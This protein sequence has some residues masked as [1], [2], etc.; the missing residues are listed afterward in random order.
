MLSIKISPLSGFIMPDIILSKVVFP[1]PLGP[2]IPKTS[3]S[4]AVNEILLSA[5]NVSILF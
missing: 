1:A 5:R 2:R 3:P 4:I